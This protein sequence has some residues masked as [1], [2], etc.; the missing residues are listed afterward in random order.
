MLETRAELDSL[1][2]IARCPL[3][4]ARADDFRS[5]FAAAPQLLRSA[6]AGG[7]QQFQRDL[8]QLMFPDAPFLCAWAR[9]PPTT[10][11]QDFGSAP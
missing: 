2:E 7:V 5:F 6:A 3:V 11:K 10:P 4:A 9:G 1:E 8:V